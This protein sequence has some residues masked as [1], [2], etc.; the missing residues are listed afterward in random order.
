M[1]SE[2]KRPVYVSQRIGRRLRWLEAGLA[3][4][5]TDGTIDVW[6]DRMPVG[7]F[8]GHILVPPGT[9]QPTL[10]DAP[11]SSPFEE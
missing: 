7:G 6:L 1:T 8:S 5:R 2:N 10:N 11:L 4:D 9:E 3:V